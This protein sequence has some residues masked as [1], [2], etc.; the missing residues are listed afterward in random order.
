MSTQ[1]T[2]P[3]MLIGLLGVALVISLA[4][5]AFAIWK[6]LRPSATYNKIWLDEATRGSVIHLGRSERG[7]ATAAAEADFT[8]GLSRRVRGEP[9]VCEALGGRSYFF[10]VEG[11]SFA[12]AIPYVGHNLGQEDMQR[13]LGERA[14]EQMGLGMYL[15]SARPEKLREFIQSSKLTRQRR[16]LVDGWGF[17]SALAK[18]PTVALS[19]CLKELTEDLRSYCIWGVGRAHW[20]L[21]LETP[22]T[23]GE[24]K[25][26]MH[27][28][29]VFARRFAGNEANFSEREKSER[30]T[31]ATVALA[32]LVMGRP[33]QRPPSSEQWQ[34][35]F[36]KH[37]YDC[38]RENSKVTK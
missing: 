28:G 10:C 27:A 38:V 15:S 26:A 2:Q 22:N 19:S 20:F 35:L 30:L 6:W 16:Y 29:Q 1:K 32:D 4:A 11:E 36:E 25:A 23:V 17:G 24:V 33:P 37:L 5:N 8:T 31:L 14:E 3:K 18:G 13:L 34:C 12:R 9:S 21:S 7:L